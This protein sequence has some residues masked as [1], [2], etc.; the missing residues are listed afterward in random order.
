MAILSVRGGTKAFG[1]RVL[2][3]DIHF[4]IEAKDKVGLV[5][6]NGCGKTTLLRVLTGQDSFTEG[7]VALAHGVRVG[8]L[9]QHAFGRSERSLWDEVLSVFDPLLEQERQ[10][11]QLQQTLTN[12]SAAQIDRYNALREQFEG[13]GG[14]YFRSR[15]RSM[16]LGLGFD[17]ESFSRPVS[18]FSGGQRSKAAMG[19]LLLGGADLLLLDE[20]TN[21]LDTDAAEWLEE[22]LRGYSGAVVVVSH[23]RY[24]LDQ[25]THRTLE[26]ADGQLYATNG[27]Y[28]AHRA[29]REKQIEVQQHHYQTAQRQVQKMQQSIQTLKSFNREKSIRAAESK[30]K[31]LERFTAQMEQAPAA[32]Q[33]A[34]AL[35]FPVRTQSG[36]EVLQV[37]RVA[38][39]YTDRLF[40]DASLQLLRGERM[41]LLGGNGCGKTTFLRGLMGQLP[42]QSGSVRLGAKVSIGYYDQ[43]QQGLCPEKTVIEQVHDAYPHMTDTE[44]RNALAAFLFR[45]DEVFRPIKLLS[46]GE[47]ARVLLLTLMLAGHNLLLL[48]EPTNHLDIASREA[49]EQALLGYDGTLLAVSHD[50]Y[51]INRLATKAVV[52]TKQG[53]QACGENYTAY[54]AWKQAQVP[55]QAAPPAVEK[56]ENVYLQRKQQAAAA[57]KAAADVRRV[58]ALISEAE[59]RQSAL[60]QQLQQPDIAADYQRIAEITAELEMLDRQLDEWMEQWEQLQQ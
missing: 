29:A 59:E 4:Q 18:T 10:L 45:G 16:L 5:G 49:L 1:E 40:D 34:M 32:E 9:E 31:A 54:L 43:T 17:E 2:F 60:Q 42:L 57:R 53:I 13:Q 46:G 50:R 20:P 35:T 21:H 37:Q 23:D 26:I 44:A 3:G 58:E 14:L 36:N 12:A 8:C 19:R 48:D 30:E 41:F 33:R 24:F 27:N 38:M 25:V 51:F 56:K 11:E 39:G 55:Q 6:S 47:K 52:L 28:S 22:Y 7:E 15:V